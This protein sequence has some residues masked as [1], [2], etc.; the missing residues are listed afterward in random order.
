M[1]AALVVGVVAAAVLIAVGNV[2]DPALT[3]GTRAGGVEVIPR[4]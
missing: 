4:L 3:V 2:H 1:P